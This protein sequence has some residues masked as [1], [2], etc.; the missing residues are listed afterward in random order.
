MTRRSL[1]AILSTTFVLTLAAPA[2]AQE[3]ALEL[4]PIGM[5]GRVEVPSAGYALTLPDDWVYVF[6]SEADTE[7]LMRATDEIAPDLAAIMASALEQGVGLSLLA[8]GDM[9]EAAGFAE[10]CNV[11]DLPSPGVPL[12]IAVAGEAAAVGRLEQVVSGP[13]VTELE[14]PVGVAARL[15]YSLAFPDYETLHSTYYYDAGAT[16]FIMTCTYLERPDDA[17]LSIAETFELLEPAG[18]GE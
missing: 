15:D 3:P 7:T 2:A 5:G 14:L 10:N 11:I 8:F 4:E 1:A 13:D 12:R 6:P 9:D 16:V 18:T 17:W